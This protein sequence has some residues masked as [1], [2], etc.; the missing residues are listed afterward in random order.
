MEKNTMKIIKRDGACIEFDTHKICEAI[1]NSI[2]DLFAGIGELV[3]RIVESASASFYS[4][5][6]SLCHWLMHG[7]W[8]RKR[9]ETRSGLTHAIITAAILQPSVISTT[10]T[11][12]SYSRLLRNVYLLRTQDR[13]SDDSANTDYFRYIALLTV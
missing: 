9:K 3:Q 10:S 12:C 5:M 2:L 4:A 13:S 7:F 1:C 11:F 8:K 6:H